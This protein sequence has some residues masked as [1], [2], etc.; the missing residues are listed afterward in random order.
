MESPGLPGSDQRP[1]SPSQLVGRRGTRPHPRRPARWPPTKDSPNVCHQTVAT[2]CLA[3]DAGLRAKQRKAQ[4]RGDMTRIMR[5]SDTPTDIRIHGTDLVAGYVTGPGKWPVKLTPDFGAY[6]LPILT[7][8]GPCPKRRRSSTS[9]HTVR[10]FT[11]RLPGLRK[12]KQ[13]F[14]AHILPSSTVTAVGLRHCATTPI[15]DRATMLGLSCIPVWRGS[16]S[17][18]GLE[19]PAVRSVGTREAIRARS[20]RSAT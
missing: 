17:V 6:R 12:G 5:D 19:S 16:G 4:A 13:L 3:R 15:Q 20:D 1:R 11:R 18:A 8:E 14:R 7:A 9:N 10:A 2:G